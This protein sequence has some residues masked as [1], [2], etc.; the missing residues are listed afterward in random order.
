MFKYNACSLVIN[1]RI[2]NYFTKNIART[3]VEKKK[4]VTDT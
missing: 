1:Y 3:K 2:K 4:Y